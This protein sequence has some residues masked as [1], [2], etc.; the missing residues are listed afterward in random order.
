MAASSMLVC[1]SKSVNF[2]QQ[3]RRRSSAGFTLIEI[4]VVMVIMAIVMAVA[5]LSFG[6]LDDD[7]EIGRD[8]TR[9]SSL[10]ELARDEATIQG[11]D[12]GLEF[13]RAGYRF[14]EHDPLTN[15]WFE[16][17]GDDILRPREL[18][19]DLE[20]E[21]Y[22]E[23]Q[24]IVLEDEVQETERD[25]DDNEGLD[26]YLPHVLI[27]SSGDVTPF[28]LRFQRQTDRRELQLTMSPAGVLE[29]ID[30]ESAFL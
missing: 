6:I 19:A 3:Y 27:L 24:R 17:L 29:V 12:L 22:L 4:L 14:V 15:Q 23:D 26:D 16:I 9:L 13:L 8:A 11:R 7:R 25:E 5:L 2:K 10:I 20:L 28:E 21:L 18:S 1:H 30:D